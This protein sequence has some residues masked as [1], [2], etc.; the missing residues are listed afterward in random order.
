MNQAELN[1][2]AVRRG[3]QAFNADDLDTLTELFDK[4][5]SWH[6]PGRGPFAGDRLGREAVFQLFG[7][8]K[9]ETGGTFKVTLKRVLTDAEGQV[10][11]VHHATAERKGKHLEVDG[12]IAFEFQD[13]KI[14]RGKEFIFDLYPLDEFW[15]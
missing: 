12:C 14:V 11:S 15:E 6:T 4:N 13:G 3:Y 2:D 8:Y 9:G 7:S 5:V 1:A 10:I